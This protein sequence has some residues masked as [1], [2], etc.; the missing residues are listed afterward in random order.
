MEKLL[1]K[2]NKIVII[3]LV[4]LVILAIIAIIVM[5]YRNRYIGKKISRTDNYLHLSGF[6]IFFEKAKGEISSTQVS[7]YLKTSITDYIPSMYDKIQKYNDD[8]LEEYYNSN[9]G[10]IE[11]NLGKE[12]YDDYLEFV[13][14]IR[15]KNVDLNSWE[16]LN[17]IKDS[18]VHDSDKKDYSY[19]QFDVTYLKGNKI[20][21]SLYILKHGNNLPVYIIDIV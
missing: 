11:E 14:K 3:L 21:F 4:F 20:R 15:N 6:G 7:N 2:K 5:N 13:K 8:K 16:S 10:E 19:V 18:F 1:N 9:K 17:I 12:S